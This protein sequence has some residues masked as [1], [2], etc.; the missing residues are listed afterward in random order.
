MKVYW[1]PSSMRMFPSRLISDEL[2]VAM[3]V[4]SKH[5]LACVGSWPTLDFRI[6]GVSDMT[7]FLGSIAYLAFLLSGFLLLGLVGMNW[8]IVLYGPCVYIF[9]IYT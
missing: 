5:A 1:A 2:I 3:A 8:Y 6:A 9:Y 4:L 7:V